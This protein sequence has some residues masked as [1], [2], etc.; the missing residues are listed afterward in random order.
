MQNQEEAFERANM[1]LRYL[2]NELDEDQE[3]ALFSWLKEN[4]ENLAFFN[5]LIEEKGLQDELAFFASTKKES[6][7]KELTDLIGMQKPVVHKTYPFLKYAA[8]AAA[9]LLVS[10]STFYIFRRSPGIETAALKS[11]RIEIKPGANKAVLTLGN[12]QKVVLNDA[13]NG[14]ISSQTGVSITKAKDGQIIYQIHNSIGAKT[15]NTALSYNTIE[16]PRGGKYQV[17]LP[18]GS[19]VWLNAASSLRYPI[20]FKNL[21]KREVQLRGEGYFEI[22]KD[23][24]K[25]FLVL[26][27]KQVVEVLGTHFNINAYEEEPAI[28]S[29]LLEGAVKVS[30]GNKSI[31]IKPGEQASL[32]NKDGLQI[33]TVNTE[34]AI[35]WVNEKFMFNSQDLGSIMRSI[36]RWYDIEVIYKDDL[37]KK[38]FTGTISRFKNVSEV[39]DMLELTEMVHFHIAGRRITVMK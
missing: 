35:A 34:A 36:S 5:K 1:M 17:I 19:H 24:H 30:Y 39:L 27:D 38:K 33:H 21:R 2:R 9:I 20:S 37:S 6:A 18:D 16:T 11:H 15:D 10:L 26:C 8:A 3:S 23:Q 12:G 28:T 31:R 4:P 25:P 14:E 7:W 29:T 32:N 22:S 13:K